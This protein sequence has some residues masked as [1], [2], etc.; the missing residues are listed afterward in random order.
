M[1]ILKKEDH[2]FM[3]TISEK[4][5]MT[6]KDQLLESDDLLKKT[7]HYAGITEL[8][9]RAEDPLRYES[10]HTKLRSIA[11]EAREMARRISASPGVREWGKWLLHYIHQKG[12]PSAFPPELWYMSI[13]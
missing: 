2:I 8:E 5:K 4:E 10:L 3:N 11:V 13:R 1:F 7:G 6:L 12:M 9:Y